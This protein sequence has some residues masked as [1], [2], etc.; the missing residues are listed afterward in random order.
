[1]VAITVLLAAVIASFVLGLGPG[2]TAPTV[3]L[4][5]EYESSSN[6]LVVSVIGGDAVPHDQISFSGSGIISIQG[7]PPDRQWP[8]GQA[9]GSVDGETVIQSGDDVEL[10]TTSDSYSIDVVWSAEDGD[11]TQTL[12]T[13]ER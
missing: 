10:T 12:T 9:S 11:S 7:S 4:D 2:G 1:M 5:A 6:T 13:F 8:V 3:N